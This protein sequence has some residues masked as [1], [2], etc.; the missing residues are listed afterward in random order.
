[1]LDLVHQY[2]K[3]IDN[4]RREL[5]RKSSNWPSYQA[6]IDQ[7]LTNVFRL[8]D[9]F[10]RANLDDEEKIYKMKCLFMKHF[11]E[12]F[13]IGKYSK[14][15]CEKPLG[16]AGDFQIIEWIYLNM[17]ETIGIERCSD[18]YFL[19]T[20][21][22]IAT[23]NRKEDFKKMLLENIN[24]SGN[25]DFRIMDLACGPCRDIYELY[26]MLN[27]R[28]F[29]TTCIDHDSNAIQY[30]KNLID[31]LP[32]KNN[33][34]FIQKNVVRIALSR[35][36]KVLI[37]YTYDIIFST[38]LFDYLNHKVSVRLVKNLKS[39]L[40][41]GGLLIISNYRDKFNNPSRLY[42]EWGGNW[43]LIY[44]TEEE[45]FQIFKEAGFSNS[46]LSLKFESQKIM[47]YCLARNNV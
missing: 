11:G 46:D 13:K 21:A 36:I 8:C 24:T 15:V 14:W 42:M 26:K 33:I 17:P 29:F 3:R 34:E 47:Q 22:S 19:K 31:D 30:A 18:N 44:R 25:K 45:F 10:E 1:M 37:P 12:Y 16:Y 20:S 7:C 2:E 35:D 23:R 38:G 39:L 41:D 27:G 5:S 40:K 9:E 28:T 43:E 32:Q 6:E 4:I